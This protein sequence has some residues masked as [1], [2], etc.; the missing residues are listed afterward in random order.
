MKV[1]ELLERASDVM[2]VKRVFG[3]PFERD[4][5]TVIPVVK[6]AGGGGGGTDGKLE[7]EAGGGGF[8]VGATP[9]G[10][11]VIK[12]GEVSWQPAFDLNRMIIGFQIVAVFGFIALRSHF[13]T[14]HRAGRK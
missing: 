9:A 13:K 6:I 5:V 4:G 7:G 14:R 3:P 11:Y 1:E 10:A 8:G 12:D 2:T